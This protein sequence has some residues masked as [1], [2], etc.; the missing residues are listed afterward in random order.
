MRAHVPTEVILF[1]QKP[2]QSKIAWDNFPSEEGGSPEIRKPLTVLPAFPVPGDGGENLKTTARRWATGY[3]EKD[4]STEVLV[5]NLFGDL[6][7]IDL[8]QRGN[9]GRAWKVVTPEGYLFDLRE[10]VFLEAITHG[11]LKNGK[12]L[13]MEFC[14]ARVVTQMK[15]IRVGSAY[16]KACLASSVRRD[17]KV[18]KDPVP[19]RVYKTKDGKSVLWFGSKRLGSVVAELVWKNREPGTSRDRPCD[20]I[21]AWWSVKP[22]Q[23]GDSYVEVKGSTT[24]EVFQDLDCYAYSRVGKPASLVEDTGIE[25][26]LQEYINTWNEKQLDVWGHNLDTPTMVNVLGRMHFLADPSPGKSLLAS[27]RVLSHWRH[28]NLPEK[29]PSRVGGWDPEQG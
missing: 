16:H 6:T 27:P 17:L 10:D 25:V 23:A 8:E 3:H 13:K 28:L 12:L 7:V 4:S 19:G 14:F 29:V 9:G 1:C 11:N 5:P 24:E 15:L 21:L 26:N 20:Q 2:T 22:P 18:I